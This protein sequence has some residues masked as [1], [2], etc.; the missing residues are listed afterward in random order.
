M[1]SEHAEASGGRARTV[2]TGH[3][4]GNDRTPTTAEVIHRTDATVARPVYAGVGVALHHFTDLL[5]ADVD[6]LSLH[7]ATAVLT[8]QVC[9][10]VEEEDVLDRIRRLVTD[11]DRPALPDGT[12]AQQFC[13]ASWPEVATAARSRAEASLLGSEEFGAGAIL[14]LAVVRGVGAERPW[15]GTPMWRDRVAALAEGFVSADGRAAL[16]REPELV[17]DALLRAALEMADVTATVSLRSPEPVRTA[18]SN[19]TSVTSGS[20]TRR[21]DASLC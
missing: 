3:R 20:P 9:E 19:V 12:T 17:D 5:P 16:L 7:R 1:S 6:A 8:K 13:G 4:L 11:P 10:L 21:L 2:G 18:G 15:W 14:N